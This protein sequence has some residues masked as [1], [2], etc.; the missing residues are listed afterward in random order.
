MIDINNKNEIIKLLNSSNEKQQNLWTEAVNIRNS[1]VGNKV[2]LRGLIEFSNICQKN[3]FYCGIRSGNTNVKRYRMNINDIM[4]CVDFIWNNGIQSV[5]LQSGELDT[6][7]FKNYLR[8]IVK[9]IKSK[10]KN[11]AITLS[12]GE[13]DYDFY[14]E[15]H[16]LGVERYLLRIES[17]NKDFYSKIH[18]NTHNFE[19]RKQCL[20]DMQKIG[21]QVGTGNMIGVPNQTD[22]I[23]YED[24]KF[25][26]N[27]NFDMFGLGP[28]IIH[29]ETPLGTEENVVWWEEN[30]NKILNK[31]L[32]FIS[33]L[34]LLR[35]TV[36]I[37][38]ATA[39]DVINQDGRIMALKAGA[40]VIMPSITPNE[41]K[42]NYFLYQNKP[43]V[44]DKC[45]H[46]LAQVCKKIELANMVPA[47]NERGSSLFYKQKNENN[48]TI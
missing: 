37:A 36:N 42:Q 6:D 35:P 8:V 41:N 45:D 4:S 30:K 14:N 38:T 10:Y 18:P 40:N 25:F 16:N 15:L 29:T 34:R 33:I 27:N 17:S 9:T 2:Y 31:T 3:C 7:D 20:F 43:N 46:I 5:V 11:I 26:V 48:G 21:Y 13:F 28:Y 39:L 44:D 32:N 12:S 22:D 23:I 1:T 24:L 19:K 47:F